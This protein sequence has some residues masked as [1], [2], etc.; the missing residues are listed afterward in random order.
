MPV[1]VELAPGTRVTAI[2]AGGDHSLALTASQLQKAV[3]KPRV[4]SRVG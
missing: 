3:A 4:T 2:A 1:P